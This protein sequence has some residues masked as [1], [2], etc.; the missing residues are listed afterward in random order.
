[1]VLRAEI[2]SH[3]GQEIASP[4][5]IYYR[6]TKGRG[7]REAWQGLGEEITAVTVECF[8]MFSLILTTT[9]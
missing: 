7:Q 9:L 8:H 1:M 3:Q 5:I 2:R 4:D 6:P